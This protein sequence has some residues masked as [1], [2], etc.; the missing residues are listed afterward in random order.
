MLDD[1]GGSGGVGSRPAIG[2]SRSFATFGSSMGAVMVNGRGLGGASVA[3]GGI[4]AGIA[5][6]A[7]AEA[8]GAGEAQAQRPR[9]VARA[10]K[11]AATPGR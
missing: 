6:T 10:A 1:S 8:E 2:A 9:D 5:G 7:A 11:A 3:G 4:T